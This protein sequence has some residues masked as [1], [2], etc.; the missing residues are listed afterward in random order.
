MTSCTIAIPV[1][2]RKDLILRALDSAL[3]QDM[4]D[5]EIL[6]VDNCS[7]DGTWEVLQTYTDSRLRLARNER[8]LG[9][10][11]NFNRCLNLAQG[12]YLRFLCSDDTLVPGCL[13]REIEIMERNPN[14]S[15]LSTRNRLVDKTGRGLGEGANL[16]SPG[17]Y[18]GEQAI[19]AVLWA[20]GHYALNPLNYP[21]GVLLRRE[22]ALRVGLFDTTLQMLGDV[23]YFLRV[24]G[25]GDLAILDVVGCE[26][27][28]HRGM[29]SVNVAGEGVRDSELLGLCE[30]YKACLE[31]DGTYR[32]I[33]QQVA[34]HA[35]GVIFKYWYRRLPL[36]SRRHLEI[37]RSTGV[38]WGDIMVAIGRLISM[39]LL[40]QTAGIRLTPIRPAQPLAGRWSPPPVA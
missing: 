14:V 33:R 8:N 10:F 32:R 13:R 18:R 26:I 37:V 12:K 17:I 15:L 27:T 28:I 16:L 36:A 1:Y 23:E 4:P 7:T 38:G 40:L 39:R 25:Y 9:L 29:E 30:R 31:K 3:A 19:P 11:G 20:L 24:L 22:L 6:V 35:T 5:L 34:A 2:N 21:S